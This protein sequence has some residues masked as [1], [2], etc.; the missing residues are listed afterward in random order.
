[1][2]KMYSICNFFFLQRF[3]NLLLWVLWEC[4]IMLINNDS[5]TL[6]ETLVPKVLKSTSRPLWCLSVCK[7]ST[8]RDIVNLLFWELWKCLTISI[9]I[10]VSICIKFSCLPAC[11]R[12]TLSF[13]SFLRYCREIANFLFWVIWACLATHI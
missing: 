5:I 1:M 2:Q 8:F 9:K 12:S 7:K 10:I 4:F 3:A 6:L 11:K 13:T